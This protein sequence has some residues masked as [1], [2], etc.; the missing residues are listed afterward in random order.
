[1]RLTPFFFLHDMKVR[2]LRNRREITA[3]SLSHA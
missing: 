2:S 3:S 1:M